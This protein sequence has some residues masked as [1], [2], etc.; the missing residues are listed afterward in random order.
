MFIRIF[1]YLFR[2]IIYLFTFLYTH[3]LALYG[4]AFSSPPGWICVCIVVVAL[5]TIPVLQG[6]LLVRSSTTST[7]NTYP[8]YQHYLYYHPWPYH[9]GNQECAT[10]I[11]MPPSQKNMIYTHNIYVYCILCWFIFTCICVYLN[12]CVYIIFILTCLY[13]SH[14][15]CIHVYI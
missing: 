5:G 7:A 2:Y 3:V 12:L 8:C 4:W 6:S 11:Y 15:A 10:H 13:L 1:K 9:T 14:I